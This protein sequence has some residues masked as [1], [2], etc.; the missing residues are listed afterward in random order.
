LLPSAVIEFLTSFD[1]CTSP[2][3][4]I[5]F[6]TRTSYAHVSSDGLGWNAVEMMALDF[7]NDAYENAAVRRFWDIHFPFMMAVHSDYDY[8]A[9]RL[10]EGGFGAVVHGFAP[11]WEEPSVVTT[12]FTD[13]LDLFASAAAAASADYPLSVFL[14]TDSAKQ[15]SRPIP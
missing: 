15:I 3:D 11:E 4:A 12:S 14:D 10:S 6:L 2:D 9:I 5:W 1:R 13:F 7:C 8:L